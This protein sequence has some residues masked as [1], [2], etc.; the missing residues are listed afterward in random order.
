MDVIDGFVNRISAN[1]NID[2]VLI[3]GKGVYRVRF[4]NVQDKLEVLQSGIFFFDKKPF[5]VEALNEGLTL[6][7]SFL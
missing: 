5:I 2:I 7:I 3:A 1:M 4:S 6:D